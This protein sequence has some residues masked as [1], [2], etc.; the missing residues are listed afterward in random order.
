MKTSS[1]MIGISNNANTRQRFFQVT[2]ELSR[3]SKEFESQFDIDVN[4]VS[5]HHE[6]R[7]GTVKKA[8]VTV[9]KIK[10]A[11]LSHGNPFTTEGKIL[12]N[13]ITNAYIPD[14]YTSQILIVDVSGQKLYEDYFTERINGDV[15]LW[16]S[17]K[18]VNN[19]MF[20][21]GNKKSTLR[22]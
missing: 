5:E 2:P 8:H 10:A 15:S 6:L 13:I 12:H 21:S 20:L 4:T 11:L 9:D 1:G 18:R 7:P 3:L 17:V 22:S 19:K 14:E 16:S